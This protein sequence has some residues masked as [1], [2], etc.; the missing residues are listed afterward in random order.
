MVAKLL[1]RLDLEPADLDCVA[2]GCGPGSF[3]GVRVAAS[4]TQGLAFARGIPVCQVSTLQALAWQ[5]LAQYKQTPPT[6][7]AVSLDARMGEAYVGVYDVVAGQP[8]AASYVDAL[9][10]PEDFSLLD[11]CPHALALGEGWRVFPQLRSGHE[12][13]CEPDVWPTAIGVLELARRQFAA[14]DTLAPA[15]A[16]PN[17]LRNKVTY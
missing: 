2:F 12:G 17:Y 1:A 10:K 9:V 16:L 6:A 14:G 11:T 3:T 15:A 7:V 8:G 5:G 13:S 4:A